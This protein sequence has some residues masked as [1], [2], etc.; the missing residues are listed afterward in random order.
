MAAN[1][2][3]Y[4]R[5]GIS[6]K[7]LGWFTSIFVLT[8]STA[9]MVSLILIYHQNNV[10]NEA[11]NN[12]IILKES[13]NNVQS[14]SD[15]LTAEA[16]LFVA[17][18]DKKYMD[19][20]FEEVNVKKRREKAL[21]NI[22]NI[23][24]KTSRH[25]EIHNYIH[26]AV[27]ESMSLMDLEFYAMKLICVDQNIPFA[28]YQELVNIDVEA[29]DPADR[30]YEAFNA[31]LGNEYAYHKERINH[32]ISLAIEIIDNL[33]NNNQKEASRNLRSLI[34]FQSIVIGINI[35]F[36]IVAILLYY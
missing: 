15:Y 23:A 12:Y 27:E 19:N 22:H 18:A 30:K 14:A 11:E 10:V 20:Y 32:N 29:V 13:S 36:V 26:S 8:I 35:V 25:E 17:N 7:V 2:K 16:R 33:I 9:L 6:L 34:V 24:E 1:E 31:V 5:K 4:Q 21:E 3:R 28:E